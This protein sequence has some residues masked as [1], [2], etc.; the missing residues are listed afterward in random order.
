MAEM[1]NFD[2]PKI[3]RLRQAHNLAVSEGLEQFR[4]EGRDLLTAYAKEL[5]EFLDRQ[6]SQ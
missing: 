3:E 5:L 2:P 6:K 4:F 1:V